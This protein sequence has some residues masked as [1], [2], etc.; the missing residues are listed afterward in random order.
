MSISSSSFNEKNGSEE[1]KLRPLRFSDF[2]GQEK[3]IERLKIMV[4][5]AKMRQ[6]ALNH[7]LLSGPPEIGRAHV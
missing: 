3:T 1:N 7:I 5:A 6:D 2:T 4:G